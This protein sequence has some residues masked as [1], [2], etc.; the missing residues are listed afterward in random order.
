MRNYDTYV[1]TF[2]CCT[3]ISRHAT[4]CTLLASERKFGVF[5]I[6]VQSMI[7]DCSCI[8]CYDVLYIH[9]VQLRNSDSYVGTCARACLV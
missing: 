6:D 5:S 4:S 9:F 7:S 3:I 2:S 1:L 8:K